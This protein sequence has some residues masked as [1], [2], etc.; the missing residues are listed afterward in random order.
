VARPLRPALTST[1]LGLSVLL[2]AAALGLA[3]EDAVPEGDPLLAECRK[4]LDAPA[5]SRAEGL[6]SLLAARGPT[7]Y[8]RLLIL[9]TEGGDA[10]RREAIALAVAK[11]AE[12]EPAAWLL[13]TVTGETDVRIRLAALDL[14][15]DFATPHHLATLL[16]IVSSAGPDLRRPA[17]RV[18]V[19]AIDRIPERAL[20][21]VLRKLDDSIPQA[22]RLHLSECVLLA[23]RTTSMSYLAGLLGRNRTMDLLVLSGLGRMPPGQECAA[24]LEGI[25]GFL[26]DP[27]P[28]F[29]RQSAQALGQL[30]DPLAAGELIR[31]LEDDSEAVRSSALWALRNLS[32]LDLPADIGRWRLWFESE[33]RW[34]EEN[35]LKLLADLGSPDPDAVAEAVRLLSLSTLHR[36]EVHAR[37]EELRDSE[38]ESVR[39]LAEAVLGPAS[40]GDRQPG[41]A[42]QG[43]LVWFDRHTLPPEQQVEPEATTEPPKEVSRSGALI[44]VAIGGGVCLILFLRLLG[45]SHADRH[46]SLKAAAPGPITI[47]IRHRWSKPRPSTPDGS[48]PPAF[49]ITSDVRRT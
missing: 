8:P 30:M 14:L 10:R 36:R 15:R 20:P 4:I 13:A 22:H 9:H 12:P 16:S 21:E 42:N 39:D 49:E 47:S 26:A 35:G 41:P 24:L 31:L 32:G 19:A 28:A 33:Q 2:L 38:S 44:L 29:R 6:A 43:G 3:R 48:T 37:L 7:V 18:A 34:W 27:D 5:A 25:R 11:V 40:S 45:I 17:E 46:R 23:S 1:I